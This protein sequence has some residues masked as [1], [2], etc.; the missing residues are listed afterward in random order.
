M[1]GFSLRLPGTTR[2]IVVMLGLTVTLLFAA[3]SGDA[4]EDPN[5]SPVEKGQRLFRTESCSACHS[6]GSNRVVGPGLA[7]IKDAAGSRRP[8]LDA[9]EYLRESI[10]TPGE[11]VVD[12]FSNI[13]PEFSRLS[14]DDIDN[15][16][17]YMQT[18]E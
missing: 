7:G 10:V 12:G 17:A 14:A 16:I 9:S 18:L 8:G 2:N 4:A 3:C 11:F 1:T 13:M 6:T 5:A 15:L